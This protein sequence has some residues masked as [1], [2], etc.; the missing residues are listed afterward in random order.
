MNVVFVLDQESVQIDVVLMTTAYRVVSRR[1]TNGIFMPSR[2]QI[3]LW[4]WG[5]KSWK[6]VIIRSCKAL[7][8]ENDGG[9]M[10]GFELKP[11]AVSE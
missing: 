10:V 7:A 4:T 3:C 9:E 8:G 1:R 2:N 11:K 5:G 6:R